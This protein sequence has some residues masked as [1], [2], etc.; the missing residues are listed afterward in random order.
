MKAALV[1]TNVFWF[2]LLIAIQANQFRKY[3]YLINEYDNLKAKEKAYD[4]HINK[5]DSIGIYYMT[6]KGLDK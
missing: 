3:N 6:K 2:I 4:E 1:I 5:C